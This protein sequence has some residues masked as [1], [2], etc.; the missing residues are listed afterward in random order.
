MQ[1]SHRVDICTVKLLYQPAGEI[2]LTKKRHRNIQRLPISVPMWI[3]WYFIS[4]INCL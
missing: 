4:N 2:I 3:Q 1:T